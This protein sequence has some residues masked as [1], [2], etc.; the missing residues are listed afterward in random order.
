MS[1]AQAR[2]LRFQ[3]GQKEGQT[4][5]QLA[6]IFAAEHGIAPGIVVGQLQHRKVLK[7]HHMNHLKVRYA[8]REEPAA[9]DS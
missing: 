2:R 1:L 8:W 5:V 9:S 6:N 4:S 3:A 7:F